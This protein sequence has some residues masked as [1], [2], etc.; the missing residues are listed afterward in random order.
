MDVQQA[1]FTQLK[2][3][4]ESLGYDVYDG[5]LPPEGTAYPFVYLGNS[6]Q[7]DNTTKS[8]SIG[9]M[10]QMIHVWHSNVKKR[11]TVSD[12]IFNIKN[13]CRNIEN[14]YP[15]ILSG[16]NQNIMPDSTTAKPLIHGVI[17][18]NFKF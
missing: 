17:T 16:M 1:V 3:D 10:S 8:G 9:T 5:E 6:T 15:V 2:V 11:G 4:I 13:I 7:N 14:K 12:M 18:V